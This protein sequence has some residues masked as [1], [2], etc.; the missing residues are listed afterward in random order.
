MN[1]IPPSSSDDE[2]VNWSDDYQLSQVERPI[3]WFEIPRDLT[4]RINTARF[5]EGG[6][7]YGLAALSAE[8]KR[9]L[10]VGEG[11][12]NTT[13]WSAGCN[14]GRLVGGGEIDLG[15]AISSLRGAALSAGLGDEEIEQVLLRPAGALETGIWEPRNRFGSLAEQFISKTLSPSSFHQNL[16]ILDSLEFWHDA[17]SA[18]APGFQCLSLQWQIEQLGTLYF[19]NYLYFLNEIHLLSISGAKGTK[20]IYELLNRQFLDQASEFEALFVEIDFGLGSVI[21]NTPPI[22]LG[23]SVEVYDAKKN[24]EEGL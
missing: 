9:V 3:G 17:L 22:A 23:I 13:L 12:R 20:Q 5:P 8:R 10:G 1:I 19:A 16:F 18:E 11:A 7:E 4:R 2:V 24:V 21:A 14:V 6:T 15:F